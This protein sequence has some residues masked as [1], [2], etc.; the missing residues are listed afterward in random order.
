[1]HCF[2][3]FVQQGQNGSSLALNDLLIWKSQ[4]TSMK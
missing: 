2:V 3:E 1:M 4:V